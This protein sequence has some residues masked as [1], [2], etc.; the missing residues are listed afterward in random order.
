MEQKK[1]LEGVLLKFTID[2]CV[3]MLF[4]PVCIYASKMLILIVLNTETLKT[5]RG[6]FQGGEG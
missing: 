2:P 6:D 4:I 1:S 3:Q 5:L